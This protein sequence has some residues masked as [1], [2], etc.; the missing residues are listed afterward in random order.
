M[1]FVWKVS[2]L[3]YHGC[4]VLT[5][6]SALDPPPPGSR[7]G[8]RYCEVPRLCSTYRD[9][10]FG[11]SATGYVLG[12]ELFVRRTAADV[13]AADGSRGRPFHSRWMPFF[14]DNSVFFIY[15]DEFWRTTDGG[16]SFTT[17]SVH[18]PSVLEPG[19]TATVLDRF[20]F[21]DATRGWAVSDTGLV[22]APMVAHHGGSCGA[23]RVCWEQ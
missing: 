8:A 1:R 7:A 20:F 5:F 3:P 23:F 17:G 15:A 14:I 9:I 16:Q 19:T 10:F 2:C 4:C 13:G 18:L 6:R 21:L 11:T 22:G 12:R